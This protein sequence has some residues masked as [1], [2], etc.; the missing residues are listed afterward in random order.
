MKWGDDNERRARV[1]PYVVG[2][3]V[4][5]AIVV[6]AVGGPLIASKFFPGDGSRYPARPSEAD[7][8]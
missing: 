4:L 5:A 1:N 3:I 6:L 2:A 7:R 8:R